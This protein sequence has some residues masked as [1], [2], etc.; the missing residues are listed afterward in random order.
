MCPRPLCLA[1]ESILM[2]GCEA[3]AQRECQSHAQ[4]SER[5]GETAAGAWLS[6]I[7]T[8]PER[9]KRQREGCGGRV[10]PFRSS[11]LTPLICEINQHHRCIC[12]QQNWS[13]HDKQ[14]DGAINNHR[15]RMDPTWSNS[16]LYFV[17]ALWH[18]T[19]TLRQMFATALC[20]TSETLVEIF[21]IYIHS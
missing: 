1:L 20:A 13:R 16:L 5:L 14:S 12:P 11:E 15:Y 2:I 7:K 19:L 10:I 6:I 3:L 18:Q 9:G 21:Y 8:R 4:L 17:R